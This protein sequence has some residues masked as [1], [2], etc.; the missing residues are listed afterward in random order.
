LISS[1]FN[2]WGYCHVGD[3]SP[4][5]KKIVKKLFEVFDVKFIFVG[6]VDE[7]EGESRLVFIGPCF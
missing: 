7:L 1:L 6:V 3:R 5:F 4:R 2:L